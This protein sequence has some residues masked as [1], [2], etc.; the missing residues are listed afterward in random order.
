[1]AGVAPGKTYTPGLDF[2]GVTYT[3]PAKK[4][5]SEADR[6]HEIIKER[7]PLLNQINALLAVT[8][9][10]R[11]TFFVDGRADEA[12]ILDSCDDEPD[13]CLNIKPEYIIQFYENKLEPRYGLFKDAFFNEASMPSGKIP[14]AIKFADLLT[15]N[16]PTP[17]KPASAFSRLPEPTEDVEQVKR[18][19][20]EFG[21]GLAKNVLSPEQ[22]A[23]MRKAVVEQAAGERKAGSK[24]H[25][26]HSEDSPLG[27]KPTENGVLTTALSA[28]VAQVDGGP[29]GPNQRLWTLINKGD[30]FLDLLNHPIIDEFVPWALGE[31]AVITTYTANIARP[32][33]KLTKISLLPIGNV[34][35]QLHTDQVAVQPPIRDIAFGINILFYLED[36]T[37]KNG[38]T[39]VYPGSHL[40]QVAPED[41]YLFLTS[42][43]TCPVAR[44]LTNKK[45][46]QIFTVEGSHPAEAPAGTALIVDSRIWHATGPNREEAGERPLI[47]LF[48]MRSFIRQQENNFLSLR[49][50]DVWPRLSDRHKRMLGFY[51]T[52]A[53]GGVDGEVREG[54][55][56]E[57][58]DGVGKMREPNDRS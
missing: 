18:D 2:S 26:S 57:W 52:G 20:E 3:C 32:V 46:H 8:F 34:P 39:R 15:P 35:M 42:Y 44:K 28:T 12:K 19:I 40:G 50:S 4:A 36:V 41:V 43:L 14:V 27:G 45:K 58:K 11:A 53:L 16:P 33:P 5:Q 24:Y 31:H 55:L 23:I 54:V 13:C 38:A 10:D 7:L 6:A 25:D 56:V 29:D 1:M 47:L 49:R 51:T 22:V 30:D 17:P 48:F 21:Y 9:G 37:E